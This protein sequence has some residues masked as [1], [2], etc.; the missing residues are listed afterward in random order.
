MFI[1]FNMWFCP[2][3]LST[4]TRDFFHF[5]PTPKKACRIPPSTMLSPHLQTYLT[6][7]FL[8]SPDHCRQFLT[9]SPN[10]LI[11]LYFSVSAGLG[12]REPS[13][14]KSAFPWVSM[15]PSFAYSLSPHL[16]LLWTSGFRNTHHLDLQFG[17][18]GCT[19]SSMPVR[20]SLQFGWCASP[21]VLNCAFYY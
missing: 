10:F 8:W 2:T 1:V 16:P 21:W 19:R 13:C 9:A 12:W 11:Y 17:I 18:C 14:R 15:G 4:K 3:S 20:A 6:Y 5:V 7:T